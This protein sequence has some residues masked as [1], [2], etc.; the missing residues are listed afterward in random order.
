[1]KSFGTFSIFSEVNG[2]FIC[3]EINQTSDD[4]FH[5]IKY[6]KDENNVLKRT[7]IDSVPLSERVSE[8]EEELPYVNETSILKTI[9]LDVKE[10]LKDRF[11]L[12]DIEMSNLYYSKCET[13]LINQDIIDYNL[14][15]NERPAQKIDQ[16]IYLPFESLI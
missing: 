12:S 16:S 7:M 9:Y 3:A 15:I 10:I 8:V 1:M 6:M 2:T 13:R 11:E 5:M 4:S 14:F